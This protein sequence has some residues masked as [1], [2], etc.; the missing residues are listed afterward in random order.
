[1]IEGREELCNVKGNHTSLEA[2]GPA[3]ANEVGEKE[4]SIFS[5]PLRDTTKLVGMKDTVLDSVKL[6]LP[7]NHLL[8]ELAKMLSMLVPLAPR[9]LLLVLVSLQTH[10]TLFLMPA[11]GLVNAFIPEDALVLVA[12]SDAPLEVSQ[13]LRTLGKHLL[14][15]LL[16]LRRRK[17]KRRRSVLVPG[18]LLP[19]S[20]SLL[21]LLPLLLKE[22]HIL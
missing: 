11:L 4:T 7:G 16:P 10:S 21:L 8:N 20:S 19:L 22:E 6:E 14:S 15:P 9:L 1:V 2:L 18:H 17:V 5:R 12:L 3:R 13:L